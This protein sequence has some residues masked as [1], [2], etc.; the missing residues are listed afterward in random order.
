[1]SDNLTDININLNDNSLAG[2]GLSTGEAGSFVPEDTG[3]VSAGSR[4]NNRH[5]A[6]LAVACLVTFAVIGLFALRHRPEKNQV[7]QEAQA[8]LDL[9]LTKIGADKSP[10]KMADEVAVTDMLIKA[11]YEYPTD[12]QVAL[13]ELRTNPFMMTGFGRVASNS[14]SP[15]NRAVRVK[16]IKKLHAQLQLTSVVQ[17]KADAQCMINGEVFRRGDWVAET[18]LVEEI[19]RDHVV[20]LAQQS[21]FVLQI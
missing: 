21:K 9:I 20:L 3:S 19:N 12:R 11:F 5:T 15:D 7:R 17:G 16:E 14:S 8:K 6:I 2:A 1:M 18:F 4:K 13:S 10:E